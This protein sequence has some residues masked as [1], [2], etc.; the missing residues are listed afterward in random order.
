VIVKTDSSST[1]TGSKFESVAG[2]LTF[3]TLQHVAVTANTV[4]GTVHVFVNGI[5]APLANVFGPSS[6]SGNFSV[7]H[8]LYLGRR[9]DASIEGISG[10]GYFPG[11]LDEITLYSAELQQNDIQRIVLAGRGGK[12]R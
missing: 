2:T 9:Q 12:C 5:E 3:G 1:T 6:F 10:A 4:T 7:V 8:N 11:E